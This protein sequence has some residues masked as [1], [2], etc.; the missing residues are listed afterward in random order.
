MTD[1]QLKFT[2]FLKDYDLDFDYSQGNLLFHRWLP[3]GK[4]HSIKLETRYPKTELEIW[5]ERFGFVKDIEI[6]FNLKRRE[7]D[8][9]V[10]DKM[11]ILR[12]GPLFGLFKM[13]DISSDDEE[14]LRKNDPNDS[15]YIEFG[16]KI[17]RVI[18]EPLS[19]FI[20]LLRLTYGQHWLRKFSR[21]NSQSTTVENYFNRFQI[22]FSI[23]NGNNWN[24]FH[25]QNVS[26]VAVSIMTGDYRKYFTKKDWEKL[27]EEVKKHHKF[28]LAALL[29]GESQKRLDQEQIKLAFIEGVSALDL[30]LTELYRER[31]SALPGAEKSVNQFLELSLPIRIISTVSLK[32]EITQNQIHDTLK[33]IDIRNKIAHEGYDPSREEN[34]F[35]RSLLKVTSILLHNTQFRFLTSNTGN[36]IMPKESWEKE[37]EKFKKGPN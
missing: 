9:D 32:E 34:R 12:S 20:D 15:N 16:E 7:V 24:P 35:L 29:L 17:I 23:D 4:E 33:T 28:S 25:P 11:G 26:V 6:I 22:K 31:Y 18:D 14:T 13:G 10:M 5:F 36:A 27:S 37:Y 2:L 30:A 21:W 19:E 1:L 3:N 8:P